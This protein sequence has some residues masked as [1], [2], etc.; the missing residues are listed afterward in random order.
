MTGRKKLFS[1][2]LLLFDWLGASLGFAASA[3]SVTLT[4]EVTVVNNSD[5]NIDGY[6]HRF[7]VPVSDHMQQKLVAIRY[8]YPEG[9]ERKAH[10]RGDSDY[11][12]L[13]W[14]IP[15]RTTSVRRV[16]FDLELS[17]YNYR[18]VPDSV[19]PNPAVYYLQPRK[20]IESNSSAIQRLAAQIERT[21]ETDE[22]RLRA[23]FLL[24]QQMIEYRVQPTEGALY[25]IKHGKGDCTEFAALFVALARAMG[26][27]ARMTT[28]FLFTS[29]TEFRQPNHHSAEV[30]L[31]GKWI[32]V[33]PNLALDPKFGYGFGVG[34]AKKIVL[35]RDFSWVWSNLWPK[36]FRGYSRYTDVK[37]H[38][39]IHRDGKDGY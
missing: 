36:S 28:D 21:Y 1:T 14:N 38:W 17:S 24:P 29:R 30:Y 37:V 6:V 26:F 11:V 7:S 3:Q 33:D 15:A 10:R 32:P 4:A 23:A 34:K 2:L 5:R 39:K 19:D 16:H 9:F 20:Y 13:R 31:H 8:D 35:N 18:K 22:E 27:P 12:E 25:A